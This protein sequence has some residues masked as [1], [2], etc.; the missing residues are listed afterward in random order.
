[1]VLVFRLS[2]ENRSMYIRLQFNCNYLPTKD[3]TVELM[4][5]WKRFISSKG[6]HI[7]TKA[8]IE[9]TN[10]GLLLYQKHIDMHYKKGLLK[11]AF[12]PPRLIYPFIYFSSVGLYFV[13]YLICKLVLSPSRLLLLF[14]H[15]RKFFSFL[16]F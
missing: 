3:Q 6:P 1:M 8:Y 16:P 13:P 2:F 4:K 11:I 10:T 15:A 9:L 7:K 5:C 12:G 14:F